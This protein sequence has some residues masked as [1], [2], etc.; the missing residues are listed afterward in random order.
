MQI[1]HKGA[2]PRIDPSARIAPT[3]V[4]CGEVTIGPNCS[5]GFGAVIVAESGPVT[6]GANSVIMDTA[7]IRG[8]RNNPVVIGD[9]V[10]VGPRACLTGCQVADEVFLATGATVFNGARVGRGAEI[11]INGVV[12]LRTVLPEGA[13]VPIG[14]IAVG[15]PAQILSPDRHDEIW[16]IQKELDFPKYVFGVDRPPPGQSIMPDV[17]PRYAAALRRW[18]EDDRAIDG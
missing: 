15:D 17:M 12:H 14:W 13:T 4:V 5:I 10:L 3:A 16:A 8:V 9:N 2:A 1:E 6:I 7:V 11:R 18:H